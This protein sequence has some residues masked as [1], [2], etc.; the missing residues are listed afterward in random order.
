MVTSATSQLCKWILASLEVDLPQ[1]KVVHYC[2]ES[3]LS[4]D[5]SMTY[6]NLWRTRGCHVQAEA[7]IPEGVLKS[8][9]KVR[10]ML[11]VVVV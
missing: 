9:L 4:G 7:W 8:V 11:V 3:G 5:K 6:L 10:V 1:V 2:I